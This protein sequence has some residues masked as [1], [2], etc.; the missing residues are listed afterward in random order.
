[1]SIK[2]Y[3]DEIELINTEI[4]RNNTRNRG[5]RVRM[6]DLEAN[7]TEYFASKGQHGV[8]YKGRAI[9]LETTERRPQKKKKQKEQAIISFFEE[10]GI[11]DPNKAYNRLKDVQKGDPVEKQKLK[12]KKLPKKF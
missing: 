11:D 4:K 10:L 12:Y 3:L 6:K 8:K 9:V 1:M 7:V 2:G 5:L